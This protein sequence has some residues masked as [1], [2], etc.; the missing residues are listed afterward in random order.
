MSPFVT[1]DTSYIPHLYAKRLISNFTIPFA[2]AFSWS[3][4]FPL[5]FKLIFR[6]VVFFLPF[7]L[8]S[9]RWL[10]HEI[11]TKLILTL[12]AE[13]CPEKKKLHYNQ[14]CFL[15]Y[16]LKFLT[17]YYE[18]LVPSHIALS[19][20]P[21]FSCKPLLVALPSIPKTFNV[22]HLFTFPSNIRQENIKIILLT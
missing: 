12:F 11:D 4:I 22:N 13:Q 8:C 3:I 6:L 10:I 7:F 19:V 16:I 18:D 15:H 17:Y 2:V 1:L 14:N 21:A 9:W 5:P 20:P